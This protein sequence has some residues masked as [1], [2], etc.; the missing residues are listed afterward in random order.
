MIEV[1]TKIIYTLLYDLA[2]VP[3][4]VYKATPTFCSAKRFVSWICL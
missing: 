2:D 4:A 3:P 1:E